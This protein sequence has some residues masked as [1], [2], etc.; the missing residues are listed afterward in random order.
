MS[1]S[2]QHELF[3]I[4]AELLNHKHEN[5]YTISV[6]NFVKVYEAYRSFPLPP[7]DVVFPWLHGVDG[8]NN[9]QNLFFGVRRCLPPNYRGLMLVHCNDDIQYMESDKNKTSK[10]KK[11]RRGISARLVDS[12]LPEQLIH[13][14]SEEFI[15][16]NPNSNSR[17]AKRDISSLINLRNFQ[18]QIARFSTLCD[19]ILYGHNANNLAVKMAH[20]QRK[21]FQQRADQLNHVA[22]VAGKRAVLQ[23]NH[24]EYK[25]I[26]LEDTNFWIFEQSYPEYVLYNSDG[27]LLQ[28]R[29]L[30]ELESNE[31]REMSK[32]S[33]ITPNVWLGNT[34]DVPIV[35]TQDIV[36]SDATSN[37][38]HIDHDSGIE[39][40][41]KNTTHDNSEGDDDIF[42]DTNPH[43]FTI[44]IDAHDL[45]DMPLPSTLILASETLNDDIKPEIIH[46]DTYGSNIPEEEFDTFYSRLIHLLAFIH[47]QA[48][49]KNRRILIH[50]PDGYTETSILGLTW[51]MYRENLSLP[52]AYLYLQRLRS[53]FVYATDLKTLRQ[54]EK[55]L[56]EGREMLE[57]QTKRKKSNM[58]AEDDEDTSNT[59]V[60]KQLKIG[61]ADEHKGSDTN[62]GKKS[63]A[64]DGDAQMKETDDQEAV[65]EASIQRSKMTSPPTI[66]G[67]SIKESRV[68]QSDTFLNLV[69]NNNSSSASSNTATS[70]LMNTLSSAIDEKSQEFITKSAVYAKVQLSPTKEEEERYP[71]FFSPRFE[72][73]FPSKILPF[74]YLGNLN[75]ATNPSM[76]KALNIT[77]VV[78]V[79][80]NANLDTENFRLLYLDNLYD[81]GIDSIETRLEEVIQF[82][83]NARVNNGICLIHCRVGVSRSAAIT[84]AY[85][86]RYL[87]CRLVHAYLFVRARRLNVIIQP[88]LKFMY[89]MLRLDQKQTGKLSISWPVLCQEIHNINFAYRDVNE[90]A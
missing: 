12:V 19:L 36:L 32:A 76:L 68:K 83:E 14:D 17:A 84:I 77:H 2:R 80:E 69:S 31:M 7:D 51:I 21:L 9:A 81:D 23:A 8:N 45:A 67:A 50:C 52:E 55:L 18:N 47:E 11:N 53:F 25:I 54:I 13:L 15:N 34:Q 5:I 78:S 3:D 43:K 74:L 39:Q 86:M 66:D 29:D 79:G 41:H 89:E 63:F 64:R 87:N 57:P 60:L 16:N 24:I 28:K 27:I 4:P 65:E 40:D 88:N 61:Y 62:K 37:S 82:V 26:V 70:E 59:A 35:S 73:S 49:K 44:C 72:G 10:D 75:H 30:Y 22:K 46:F 56:F 48:D 71:W 33:E 58:V 42:Q 20:A 90:I 85:V 6:N 38:I 1:T